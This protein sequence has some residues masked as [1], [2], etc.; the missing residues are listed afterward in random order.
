MA[1]LEVVLPGE[2]VSLPSTKVGPGLSVLDQE[3]KSA[4]VSIAGF[5]KGAGPEE[6]GQKKK[7]TT[8]VDYSAKKVSWNFEN[9][10]L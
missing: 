6:E 3:C 5:L 1:S 8:W 7:K 10:K 9:S 4:V 2:K